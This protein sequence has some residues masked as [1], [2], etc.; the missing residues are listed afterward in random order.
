M[1]N[2]PVNVRR[3]L[4]HGVIYFMLGIL[5]VLIL[6]PLV[7]LVISSLKHET[8]LTS[9]P[10]VWF[11]D[12][13]QWENYVEVLT[14]PR[15][16]FLEAT[17]NSVVL[18]LLYSVPNVL[19][20][21]CAGYAFARLRAPGRGVLLIIV[22]ATMMIPRTITVIPQYVLYSRVGLINNRL[23]WLLWGI[24]ASP[25]QIVLFRQFFTSF[26]KE[27][28]DAAAID[29][30]D[31]IRTFLLIFLPNAKP[32]LAVT[33]LFSFSWVWG[34]WFHQALFLNTNNGTL[35]MT[36]ATAFVEIEKDIPIVNLTLAGVVL[37]SIPLVFV[38]FLMQRQLVKGIVTT[39]LKGG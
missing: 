1:K 37:Y 30:A 26:P 9:W 28:E 4:G 34:D 17:G 13:P 25:F 23:L 12:D 10:I 35:A 6:F 22:L 3:T 21:A 27:L 7:W 32:V 20:S 11:P 14:N 18:A 16:R 33:F 5:A 31:P 36:L 24:G 15:Y 39:G 38:Y 19:F 29:G 2:I 8:D